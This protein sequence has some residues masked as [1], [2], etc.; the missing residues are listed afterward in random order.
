MDDVLRM[1][2]DYLRAEAALAAA[3]AKARAE[4][5]A[6]GCRRANDEACAAIDALHDSVAPRGEWTN[7]L[8]EYD[9][10]RLRAFDVAASAVRSLIP[11][12]P[13][14]TADELPTGGTP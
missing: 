11:L 10:G 13:V 8:S 14:S 12:E 7:D 1:A 6:A 4:G 2:A 3:L 5:E 9:R